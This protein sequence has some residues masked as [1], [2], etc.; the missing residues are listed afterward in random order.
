MSL[1]SEALRK[2]RR[3][4]AE[5]RAQQRGV[6]HTGTIVTQRGS[7]L[8]VGLVIGSLIAFAAALGGGA[9]VW[10]TISRANPTGPAEELTASPAAAATATPQSASPGGEPNDTE[11]AMVE[12]VPAPTQAPPDPTPEILTVAATPAP[13]QP[14]P[15]SQQEI[16]AMT[17]PTEEERVFVVEADLG[18][19]TMSL[20]FLVFRSNDPF[21]EIN[22]IEV[23]EGESVDGFV[24]EK[25]ERTK[26]ILRDDQGLLVLKVK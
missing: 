2:A 20:G 19:A 18:Y 6:I 24:V 25:I 1:V 11:A 5:K 10:W 7:R 9:A 14:T 13:V 22:G 26:V 8:G 17:E 15:E 12:S 16:P 4:A 23:R 21:A 3:E